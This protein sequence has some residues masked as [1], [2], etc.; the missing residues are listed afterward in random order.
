MQWMT[1]FNKEMMENWRNKKWIWVP[2]VLILLAILDPI[3]NYYLP[4]IIEV[5]GGLPD[6][7][8]INLPEFAPA[9]VVMMS[10]SQLSS[11]GVL[12]I[13][14]MAMGTIASERKSGVSNHE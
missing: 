11:L 13:V 8:I 12:V 9:D 1:L 6:G 14:L 3:S 2:L 5:V 4:Q 7:A 10:L